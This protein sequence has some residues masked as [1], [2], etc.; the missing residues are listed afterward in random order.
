LAGSAIT[1]VLVASFAPWAVAA[2]RRGAA[3]AGMS[4]LAP[5]AT[6]TECAIGEICNVEQTNFL[7]GDGGSNGAKI[8]DPAGAT[9]RSLV[10]IVL[11]AAAFVV[12][13]RW[14]LVR[15]KSPG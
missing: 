9:A 12:Y 8:P 6:P 4:V 7:G 5:Q 10:M 11:I 2:S 15:G 13:L 1:V 14:A 3:R